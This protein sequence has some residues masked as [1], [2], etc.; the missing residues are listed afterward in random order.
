MYLDSGI[1]VNTGQDR[2]YLQLTTKL[3]VCAH[4]GHRRLG[5]PRFQLDD[6][7]ETRPAV[8]ALHEVLNKS[9]AGDSPRVTCQMPKQV[10]GSFPIR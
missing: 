6:D 8:T 4:L 7:D 2:T 3:G 5:S 1:S 10:A 9:T